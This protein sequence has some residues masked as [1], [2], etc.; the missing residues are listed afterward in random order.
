MNQN[1]KVINYLEYLKHLPDDRRSYVTIGAFD[2]VHIGHQKL[3]R[4]TVEEAR[5]NNAVPVVFTFKNHPLSVLAP[6]YAPKRISTDEARIRRFSDL[7]IKIVVL[8]QFNRAIA[9][10]NRTEFAREILATGLHTRHIVCGYN[11][12]FA[13][14]GAGDVDFLRRIGDELGFTVEEVKPVKIRNITVSSTK[15]R[16]LLTQGMV[17]TASEFLGRPYTIQ[18]KVVKGMGRGKGLSYPT[19]NLDVPEDVLI[20][21]NGVYVIQTEIEGQKIGGMMNIG[22]NPTFRPRRFSVEAHIFD[23]ERDLVGRALEIQFIKRLRDE[24][25]YESTEQLVSQLARDEKMARKFL[26]EDLVK[27][28]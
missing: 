17:T 28:E 3:I 21:A 15:I 2:G 13:R 5:K 6:T 1:V 7:G 11:F 12:R 26:P 24:V 8:I 27:S 4:R 14:E 10:L 20:P 18:G 23:F 19:A 9:D 16:E 22:Y 25:R